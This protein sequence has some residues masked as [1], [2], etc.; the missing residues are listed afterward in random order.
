MNDTP[1]MMW[2][3]FIQH[4]NTTQ[5]LHRGKSPHTNFLG[6]VA[7]Y[8]KVFLEANRQAETSTEKLKPNEA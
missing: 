5:P 3:R 6:S 2:E 4:L 1:E 7:S 8:R